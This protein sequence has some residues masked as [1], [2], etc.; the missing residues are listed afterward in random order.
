ME[1]L[2]R[3]KGDMQVLSRM[4]QLFSLRRG[5]NHGSPN[6]ASRK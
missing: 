1:G 4:P 2:Y 6:V 5:Q 3:V